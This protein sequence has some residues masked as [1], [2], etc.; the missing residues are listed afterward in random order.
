MKVVLAMVGKRVWRMEVPFLRAV[1]VRMFMLDLEGCL[2]QP[3]D[4]K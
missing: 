2:M 4:Y 3:I 1:L